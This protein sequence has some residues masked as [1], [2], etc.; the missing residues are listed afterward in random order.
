MQVCICKN[1]SCVFCSR[2]AGW[3]GPS[4]VR[5]LPRTL[6]RPRHARRAYV[7][8]LAQWGQCVISRC[9]SNQPLEKGGESR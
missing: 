5:K 2:R 8:Q 4:T 3:V 7:P 6:V 9:F 1:A